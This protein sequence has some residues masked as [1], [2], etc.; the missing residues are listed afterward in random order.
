M[1]G[2]AQSIKQA[3]QGRWEKMAFSSLP[4][5]AQLSSVG[6]VREAVEEYLDQ[7]DEGSRGAK[8]EREGDLAAAYS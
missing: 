4:K 8:K 2:Q 6:L 3:L 5:Q 1:L 7:G